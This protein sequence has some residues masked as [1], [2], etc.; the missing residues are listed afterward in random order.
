VEFFADEELIAICAASG[1]EALNLLKTLRPRVIL[2]DFVMPGM[3]GE[4]FMA[5]LHV[6]STLTAIPVVLMT[7]SILPRIEGS[8]QKPFVNADYLLSRVRAAMEQGSTPPAKKGVNEV[9]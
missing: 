2:L 4:Q 5:R 6:D 9:A 3:T 7:A 1:Q 8:V